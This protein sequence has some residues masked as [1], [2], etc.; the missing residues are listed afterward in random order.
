MERKRKSRCAKIFLI[1]MLGV[2]TLSSSM[3]AQSGTITVKG[4]VKDSNGEPIISGSVVVKGTTTGTV[5]DL[6][7]NYELKAPENGTLVFSYVGFTSQEIQIAG[8]TSIDVVLS[9]DAELLKEVVIIG[10]GSV[11]KEDLTGSVTAISA[12]SLAKGMAT[13]ASDLLI[14]K[15]PGV[16]VVTDGGA[17]GSAAKIRIRGGSS[18]KASNDP[19]IVID[20]VP[21]D[22][23]TSI[24]GMANPLASVNPNDIESFSVLKDASAAAIYGSRASNGVIIITTKK[25]SSGKPKINYNGTFSISSKTDDIDVMSADN[26]RNFVK[27]K[28]AEGSS[29]VNALGTAN[30]NWQDEIF[31]TAF[32]TDHNLSVA[33]AAGNFPYR[34]S[35]GYTNENGILKTSYMDRWTGSVNLNPKF[36][37]NHLTVQL[38]LKGIYNTNRFA[39]TGAIGAAAEFDP[40]QP[41]YNSDSKYGNGYYMSLKEDGTPIDIGLANPVATLNQKRDASR[42]KRSIGNIQFDYKMHFLPDLRANLNLGYD[43]SN[44]IGWISIEDNSPLSWVTGNFKTGFG[45]N[46]DYKQLKRNQLMDFYL[47]YVKEL[48]SHKFDVMGGYS[49][50]YFYR[51]E[52]NIYPYSE[53]KQNEFG[54]LYYKDGDSFKTE[55]YLISYFGRFNY[56]FANRYLLT[57]TLRNDGS[58]RFSKDKRWGLFPSVALAWRITEESFMKNQNLL[59]DLKLRLGY[60][61]TGQQNLGTGDYPYMAKYQYSKPGA[62]YYWGDE[63]VQLIRP[64]AYDSELK[65]EETTTYNIGLDYGFLGNRISGAVDL[66]YRKTNDM[67]NEIPIPAGSN[68]SN[69]L[70]TNIGNMTNKGIEFN[71]TARP[72]ETKDINWSLSYNVSYNKNEITKLAEDPTS[73]FRWGGIT[74]GTGNQVLVHKTGQPYGT[75]YVYEQIYDT[76]GK[77]I[78]GAYV[79]QN[80]DGIIDGEDLRPYK[81]ASPDV[82]MGLSSQFSYKNW[83]FNFALRAS[84]GN[85]VYNNIQSNREAYGGAWLMDPTGFL[86]NRV[87][88]A[89]YTN[90]SQ[91]QFISDYYIQN[92]SFLRMDNISLGYTFLKPFKGLESARLYATVQNPFIITKYKGL[93]PEFNNDGIDNNIYPRPR[94]YMLGLSLNF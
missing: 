82:Y 71:I 44:S 6:D 45:E 83:D 32:S 16:S 24:N 33:G 91:A 30:T 88:S 26:F 61:I 4:N 12:N 9:E 43:I 66:Y 72:I 65:W 79:D 78:E 76:D 94:I 28:Y 85:Y 58:S 51:S 39:D 25:G 35:I 47:N 52:S 31:R 50:Q 42:V 53:A 23:T 2:I 29:Q 17:P 93:D 57:A 18:M 49:W 67:L 48:G 5:T 27:S 46:R 77:P 15:A 55:N 20:G 89:S 19:L 8:R 14:G 59:S 40:T 86:K 63:K 10:Y 62:N 64:N 3:H 54:A 92:A 90:F 70:L 7:G 1:I 74:G 75:F 69:V 73:I 11:K 22:N 36:F 13:S 80:N 68:F 38:S 37:D 87:S 41:V 34:V 56:T 84:F 81:K 21:V 60:G